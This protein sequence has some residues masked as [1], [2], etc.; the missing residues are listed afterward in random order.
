LA[1]GVYQVYDGSVTDW[2]RSGWSQSPVVLE[3]AGGQARLVRSCL[4]Y[5]VASYT[6]SADG[7]WAFAPGTLSGR[8]CTKAMGSA[9]PEALWALGEATAWQPNPA[10]IIPGAGGFTV[11]GPRG[12]LVLAPA[13]IPLGTAAEPPD[14]P[15]QITAMLGTWRGESVEVTDGQT[16][17]DQGPCLDTIWIGPDWI[18]GPN[19]GYVATPSGAFA[20]DADSISYPK[21]AAQNLE[22]PPPCGDYAALREVTRWAMPDPGTLV[23]TGPNTRLVYA[24]PGIANRAF[25]ALFVSAAT[26]AVRLAV[27]QTVR[28]PITAV[29]EF[30]RAQAQVTVTWKN[31]SA[32]VGVSTGEKATKTGKLTVGMNTGRTAAI[33]LTGLK[34]GTTRIML[35]TASGAVGS[36]R[37]TV[38]AKAVPVRSI[39]ITGGDQ[40]I[41]AI[42]NQAVG[43]G[44]TVKPASATGVVVEWSSSA[45]SV[46]QVDSHGLVTKLEEWQFFPNKITITA[47]AGKATARYTFA[48]PKP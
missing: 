48:P 30:P 25:R 32:I 8:G 35:T 19:S 27:G 18:G 44:A 6:A 34:R 20:I 5:G 45:P 47:R 42:G 38:V 33:K 7:S 17:D 14:E 46:V 29:P 10:N 9:L 15:A 28:L 26:D 4:S 43:L 39:A 41:Q 12:T 11:T 22:Q 36:V 2:E 24:R 23:F 16:T 21:P 1:D 40:L 13:A 31:P 37:V 3:F